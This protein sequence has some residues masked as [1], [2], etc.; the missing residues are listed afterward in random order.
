MGKHLT[1]VLVKFV[2]L[3]IGNIKMLKQ[4]CLNY[5]AV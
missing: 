3:S 5:S 2:P 4:L 1:G